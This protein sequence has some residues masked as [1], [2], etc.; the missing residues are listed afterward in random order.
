M[1]LGGISSASTAAGTDDSQ[2]A[3]SAAK[4]EEDLNRFLNLLVAQLK[5]Q[6][7]LDPMDSNEFTQQLVQFASVE[8]QIFQNSSLEKL[9]NLQE[10]NQ[11]STLVDYIGTNVEV[12]GQQAPLQNGKLELTYTMPFGARSATLTITDVNGVT[13]ATRDAETDQGQHTFVW[14]GQ[15]DFGVAQPEGTYNVLVSGLD[16]DNNLLEVGHTVFGNVTGAGAD[17]GNVTL[18]LGDDIEIPLDSVLSVKEATSA[19][20]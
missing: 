7:P 18:T 20:P 17:Q 11:I 6:D 1:F 3:A 5:N 8:Q 4:L 14:D 2:S 10:A 16:V 19:D 13:V 12:T 15:N 9:I